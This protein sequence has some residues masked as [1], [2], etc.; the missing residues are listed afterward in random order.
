MRNLRT[1]CAVSLSALAVWHILQVPEDTSLLDQA[2]SNGAPL[3]FSNHKIKGAAMM[4][5]SK[6]WT[7][8]RG[9]RQCYFNRSMDLLA[10]NWYPHNS[11]P[12]ILQ[13]PQ[14]F[15]PQEQTEIQQKW[16]AL[17]IYF[18][19]VGHAFDGQQIPSPMQDE[20]KPMAPLGYKKMCAFKTYGFLQAPHVQEL[21]YM[22]YLDDD[23][24]L[25][26]PIRYD[27]FSKMKQHK[28]VYAYKQLFLDRANVVRGLEEFV[29]T[30]QQQHNIQK[31][32]NP[33]LAQWLETNGYKAGKS[34]WSFGTNLEWVD[35]RQYQKPSLLKFHHAIRDS[36]MIF[37]RRWGDAP[38]RFVLAYLFWDATQVMRICTEY[39]HSHWKPSPSTCTDDGQNP[40]IQNAVLAQLQSCQGKAYCD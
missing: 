11:Y 39:V 30:F 10:T 32:A 38:L 25:T 35:L 21:D 2:N 31:V 26:E 17:P 7:Q 15:T 16:P 22:F 3:D 8:R 27:V 18:S 34:H 1:I 4:L 9:E 36:G 33:E 13:H 19:N 5:I 24:C 29:Q 28:I 20:D 23:S 14:G 12:I 40:M 6:P 37:H